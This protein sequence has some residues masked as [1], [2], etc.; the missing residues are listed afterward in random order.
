MWLQ[1]G[2][3]SKNNV[4][5]RTAMWKI[6]VD[7]IAILPSSADINPFESIRFQVVEEIF[8]HDALTRDITRENFEEYSYDD[9]STIKN[10]DTRFIDK[11]IES[12]NKNGLHC[13]KNNRN[14][15][16]Y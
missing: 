3:P 5:S 11:T 10:V 1:D 8:E 15:T 4:L 14:H 9:G 12:T 7:Q 13:Y 6:G 16:K 2:D